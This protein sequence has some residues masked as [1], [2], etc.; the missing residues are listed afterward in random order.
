MKTLLGVLFVLVIGTSGPV[1][2]FT[3]AKHEFPTSNEYKPVDFDR[4][5]WLTI[6]PKAED[7]VGWQ[8]LVDIEATSEQ[9]REWSDSVRGRAF[10][11]DHGYPYVW[12]G[13]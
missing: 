12:K 2:V 10:E 4:L 5:H 1:L 9:V 11:R 8:R 6:D 13:N 3:M 7:P